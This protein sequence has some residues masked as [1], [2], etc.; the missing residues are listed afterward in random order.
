MTE[1]LNL[2]LSNLPWFWLG[3]MVLCLV[4]EAVTFSLTTVW[5]ALS[6]LLMIFLSRTGLPLRW[7]LLIFFLVTIL[8]L[9][10]TR[11]FAVKK[12]R[13]GRLAT[14]VNSLDGQE[15]LVVKKITK[16]EKG[17][18]KASNGVLWTALGEGSDEIA[19][20]SVCKV[21]RVEGNTLVVREK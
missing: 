21:V 5:A 1:F 16:F 4:F 20:G 19:K 3:I 17:E 10:F 11:P 6:A 18:V 2:I 7:Q 15:V 14:N 9:A 8:L 12:L 13:L